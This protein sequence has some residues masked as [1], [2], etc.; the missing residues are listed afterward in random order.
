MCLSTV[1]KD[2][3]GEVTTIM[4][5]VSR[6][7]AR[8]DGVL[9]TGMFG[10]ELFVKGRFKSMDFLDGKSILVEPDETEV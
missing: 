5:D 10:E 4:Q 7:E 9:M 2:V 1:Y 6:M 3:G 8:D